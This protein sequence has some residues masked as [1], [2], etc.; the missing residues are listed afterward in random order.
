MADSH[1]VDIK[2]APTGSNLPG[3][4]RLMR[5]GRAIAQNRSLVMLLVIGRSRSVHLS[6]GAFHCL[7]VSPELNAMIFPSH[8]L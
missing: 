3:Y 6:M 8:F 4:L 7:S 1:D 2:R 5:L